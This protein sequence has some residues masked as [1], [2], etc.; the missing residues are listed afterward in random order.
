MPPSMLFFKA[1]IADF[2]PWRLI[3]MK[4]QLLL[5][6]GCILLLC[7]WLGAFL[8]NSIPQSNRLFILGPTLLLGIGMENVPMEGC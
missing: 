7:G 4:R 2:T 6:L 3:R 8:L 5:S 1:D